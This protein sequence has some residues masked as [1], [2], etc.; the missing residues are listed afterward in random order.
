MAFSN[1]DPVKYNNNNK[2]CIEFGT[3]QG[4]KCFIDKQEW[5]LVFNNNNIKSFIVIVDPHP[6]FWLSGE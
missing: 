5:V 3:I 1:T 4:I 6:S 2:L